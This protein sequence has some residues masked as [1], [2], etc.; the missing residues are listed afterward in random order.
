[1]FTSLQISQNLLFCYR[2]T[3]GAIIVIQEE[4]FGNI[5]LF[6]SL[7]SLYRFSLALQ[8][9]TMLLGGTSDLINLARSNVFR[10][11]TAYTLAV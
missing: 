3:W 1:M 5:P 9:V 7:L 8:G 6:I 4:V 11:H 10:K 2:F